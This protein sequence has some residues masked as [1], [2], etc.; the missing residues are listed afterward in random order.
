MTSRVA[1]LDATSALI[2]ILAG[3]GAIIAT[4]MVMTTFPAPLDSKPTA[5]D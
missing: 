1:L 3:G 5:S 4:S 2:G